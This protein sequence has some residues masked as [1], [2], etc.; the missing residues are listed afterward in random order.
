MIVFLL[1]LFFLKT[2]QKDGPARTGSRKVND[3]S[4]SLKEKEWKKKA[5][6]FN[7]KN[8]DRENNNLNLNLSLNLNLDFRLCWISH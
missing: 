5:M 1:L 8:F 3:T 2:D 7:Y 4:I 6:S